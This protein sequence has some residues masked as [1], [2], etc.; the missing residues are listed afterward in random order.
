MTRHYAPDD[1]EPEVR[2]VIAPFLEEGGCRCR[3][4]GGGMVA[5]CAHHAALNT[6]IKT[7]KGKK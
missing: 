1:L 4:A 5:L 7:K 6:E 2:E 3:P